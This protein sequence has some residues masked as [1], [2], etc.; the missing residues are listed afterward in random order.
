MRHGLTVLGFLIGALTPGLAN[1]SSYIFPSV[2][3]APNLVAGKVA[4]AAVDTKL[5]FSYTPT[6]LGGGLQAI[7]IKVYLFSG[8]GQDLAV[9]RD[10]HYICSPCVINLNDSTNRRGVLNLEAQ[11]LSAG[12][13]AGSS[14]D[15]YAVVTIS[16][17]DVNVGVDMTEVRYVYGALISSVH[18][19]AQPIAAPVP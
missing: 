1:A 2:S 14:F 12:G 6:V 4:A 9:S 7:E 10:G 8:A 5:V 3:E 17:D 19:A 15:G 11:I 16:N 18:V 13:F